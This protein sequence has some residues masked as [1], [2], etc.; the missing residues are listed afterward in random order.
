MAAKRLSVRKVREVLRLAAAGMSRRQIGQSLRISHNTAAHYLR[1]AR[2]AGLSAEEAAGLDDT[3]LEARLFPPPAAV[4][5]PR[6]V[7]DWADVARE[8][9]RKGMTLQLLW[10]EYKAR[11]PDGYQ[12]TQFIR[13]FRRWQGTADVVLR[14]EHKAGERVFVDYAGQTVPIVDRETGE[15]RDAQVFVGVL[16]ASNY[17]YVEATATQALPDWIGSHVRM[18]AFFG[19]VPQVTVPDNITTGVRRPSYYE[20]DLNRTYLELAQHYGTTVIPTRVSRPRDKAKVET[21][22]QI[23]ER[24]ILA[25]LRHHTFFSLAELNAEIARLRTELNER[26]FQKLEGSRRTLFESLDKPA[27]LP[28]P[29][30]PYNF[31]HWRKAR[32][33]IDY[34]VEVERR[35][36]SVPYTLVR[37]PVDVRL[38]GDT[39]EIFHAGRR[40]ATHRRI[41]RVGA[42][43]TAAEHR[44][45]AHQK[46][47]EWS[48][49]R[50]IRWAEGIGASAGALVHKILESRPHP[51]QGY[52]ACL[53]LM[54]LG[55]R[56]SPERLEAACFRALRSGAHS[57]RSVK[58]ILEHGLDRI[59]LEEQTSLALPAQHENVRGAAYFQS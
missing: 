51:E 15:I 12:Y 50:L 47:L 57:Y 27:L 30:A 54:R 11:H 25:P 6:P 38:G 21:G 2:A 42:F 58:S 31:A 32:V 3:A 1:Q 28:L 22:V 46:H 59:P 29:A 23:A 13:H 43:S 41:D 55:K 16:G 36:Y 5:A 44:P 10:L 52:R 17:T 40:V 39:V 37:E 33:N 34:H 9:K 7:P 14:Q 19:G 24:W 18:Y 35:Y 45:R 20:P 26:P 4:D 49:S 53:G 56:Y 48:P 8:L